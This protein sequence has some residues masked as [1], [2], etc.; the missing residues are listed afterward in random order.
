MRS[1]EDHVSS[2]CTA[3]RREPQWAAQDLNAKKVITFP[4]G[5][6]II[7]YS[8]ILIRYYQFVFQLVGV[9]NQRPAEVDMG[10]FI[11]DVTLFLTFSTP[12]PPLRR[13]S[14]FHHKNVN[15]PKKICHKLQFPP[16]PHQITAHKCS[17]NDFTKIMQG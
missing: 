7:R 14:R 2:A 10:P 3:R 11:N 12:P 1:S 4:V 8:N 16:L 17:P 15:P 13:L 5:W 9:E 6:L